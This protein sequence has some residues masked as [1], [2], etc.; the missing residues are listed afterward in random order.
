[1][2][3]FRLE[4]QT[5][6]NVA[7]TTFKPSAQI[8]KAFNPSAQIPKAFNQYETAGKT[9]KYLGINTLI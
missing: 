5:R 7:D 1:M 4:K 9:I 2:L 8:P 3:S 6:K